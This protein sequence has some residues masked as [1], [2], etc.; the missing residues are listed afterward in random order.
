ME[1]KAIFLDRDGVINVERGYTHRLEDFVILEDVMLT[2]AQ[3]QA[4]GFLLI[5]ISN[6]GGIGRG[7]YTKN[8][9]EI[10]HQYLVNELKNNDIVLSEIYYCPHYPDDSNCI[11]RKPNSLMIE[12]AM[13]RFG[14]DAQ[15]SY[16]IGDKER[17]TDAALKAGVNAVQIKANS[18]LKL[19]L[20]LIV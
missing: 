10:L 7:L 15:S 3:L 18:S 16:F 13:A 6:Q 5:I 4:K 14:I 8:D 1:N 2:L 17:D 12:K 9:V 20:P 19:V 11:C